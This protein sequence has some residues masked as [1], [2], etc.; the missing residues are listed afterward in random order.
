MNTE[1]R[2]RAVAVAALVGAIAGFAFSPI[3][4]LFDAAWL[5][6]VLV[7]AFAG[8]GAIAAFLHPEW[9]RPVRA[10]G[11]STVTVDMRKLRWPLLVLFLIVAAFIIGRDLKL[12]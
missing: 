5:S 2:P 3:P 1:G 8:A 4:L 6:W 11:Q 10:P 9:T 12:F 7:P